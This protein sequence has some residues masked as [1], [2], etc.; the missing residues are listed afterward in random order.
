MD[1]VCY[2]TCPPT[3]YGNAYTGKC[4]ASCPPGTFLEISTKK[5]VVC[6]SSCYTCQGLTSNDC[7]T[8]YPH[9]SK[10]G[11]FGACSC[12]PGYYMIIYFSSCPSPLSCSY[13]N[14][15]SSNCKTCS[16]TSYTCLSCYT[17]YFLDSVYAV[18]KKKVMN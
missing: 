18:K 4:V 2:S 9:A 14:S 1:Q 3:F 15:C 10:V 5:C 12:D 8:C 16:R 13:C 17:N 6:H 11:S 7:L